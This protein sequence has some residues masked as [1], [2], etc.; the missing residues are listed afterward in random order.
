MVRKS[1]H[2]TADPHRESALVV[3]SEGTRIVDSVHDQVFRSGWGIE[4]LRPYAD[5][6]SRTKNFTKLSAE[7]A[8]KRPL[9][10]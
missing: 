7:R 2:V 1:C 3:P 9:G 6:L 5:C 10:A 4:R 8:P